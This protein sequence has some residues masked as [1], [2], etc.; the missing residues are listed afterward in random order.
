MK[1]LIL[2]ICLFV[3]VT[4]SA[5]INQDSLIIPTCQQVDTTKQIYVDYSVVLFETND[6]MNLNNVVVMTDAV[7]PYI[8]VYFDSKNYEMKNLCVLGLRDNEFIGDRF[9]FYKEYANYLVDI[10]KSNYPNIKI[11]PIYSEQ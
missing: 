1:K 7:V 8:V 10:H 9:K 5:Q 6:S 11:V 4:L 3:S 2:L